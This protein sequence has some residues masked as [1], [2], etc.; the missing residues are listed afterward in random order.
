MHITSLMFFEDNYNS[1]NNF[2]YIYQKVAFK[3]LNAPLKPLNFY[4]FLHKEKKLFKFYLSGN[5]E[6]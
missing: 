4:G 5:F 1:A 3:G 2:S 6:V